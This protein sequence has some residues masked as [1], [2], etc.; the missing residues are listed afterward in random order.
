MPNLPSVL[1]DPWDLSL[2]EGLVNPV[3][4][5]NKKMLTVNERVLYVMP[6][7]TQSKTSHARTGMS[8]IVRWSALKNITLEQFI[9]WF[10]ILELRKQMWSQK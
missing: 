1:E 9:Q 7:F 5:K 2:H 8:F 6:T 3:E 10:D 4:K